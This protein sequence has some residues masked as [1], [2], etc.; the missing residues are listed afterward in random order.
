MCRLRVCI[1]KKRHLTDI[2][3]NPSMGRH[4]NH[5]P[6][7]ALTAV[8]WQVW[9]ALLLLQ[10]AIENMWTEQRVE[11]LKLRGKSQEGPGHL[12]LQLQVG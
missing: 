12:G 6:R 1:C 10:P 7:T 5:Q 8:T 2:S 3:V 4:E 11:F 9:Q